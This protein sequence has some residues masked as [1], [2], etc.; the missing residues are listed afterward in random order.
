ME[1]QL[2]VELDAIELI[3]QDALQK[4]KNLFPTGSQFNI[5]KDSDSEA[6]FSV[7]ITVGENKYSGLCSKDGTP[8]K[9][10]E[11]ERG[12]ETISITFQQSSFVEYGISP[13]KIVL[14]CDHTFSDGSKYTGELKD[15]KKHGKG[16]ETYEGRKYVGEWNNDKQ[17]GQGT[18]TGPNG[19]TYVGEF[20][21]GLFHG[22][23]TITLK[24][25][26]KTIGIFRNGELREKITKTIK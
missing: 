22:K 26:T 17:H 1:Q 10:W 21:D 11:L 24:D 14:I 6:D 3:P 25:G 5:T 7:E 23:G 2:P 13:P 4:L 19:E 18:Y 9:Q 15:G 8:I 20:K 16:T 12:G